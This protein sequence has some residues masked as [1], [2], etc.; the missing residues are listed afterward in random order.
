VHRDDH[1][2]SLKQPPDFPPSARLFVAHKPQLQ[3]SQGEK[4]IA[5]LLRRGE[6]QTFGTSGGSEGIF[7]AV[8]IAE[9]GLVCVF[10]RVRASAIS[11]T[12]ADWEKV[13]E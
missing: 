6:S 10:I 4:H 8:N 7:S 9:C 1:F 5:R 2:P 13:Y 3:S 12:N 11:I